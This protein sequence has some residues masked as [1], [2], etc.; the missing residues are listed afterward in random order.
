MGDHVHVVESCTFPPL[1]IH[2]DGS[3]YTRGEARAKCT[4]IYATD[5]R[6][7]GPTPYVLFDLVGALCY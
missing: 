1:H 7:P 5:L 3:A 4:I 6:S 2:K